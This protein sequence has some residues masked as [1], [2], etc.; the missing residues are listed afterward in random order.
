MP[1]CHVLWYLDKYLVDCG[2]TDAVVV[3]GDTPAMAAKM[4]MLDGRPKVALLAV[5]GMK[6]KDHSNAV[7]GALQH[8]IAMQYMLEEYQVEQGVTGAPSDTQE[9]W[10]LRGMPFRIWNSNRG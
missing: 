3:V 7:G 5:P 1:L 4:A 2:D 10:L 9:Q 8:A 6:P